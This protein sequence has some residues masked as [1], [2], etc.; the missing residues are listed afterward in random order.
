MVVFFKIAENDEPERGRL[1]RLCFGWCYRQAFV[2]LLGLIDYSRGD[3]IKLDHQ[4]ILILNSFLTL[5][6]QMRFVQK[7]VLNQYH[8]AFIRQEALAT[9]SGYNPTDFETF[10]VHYSYSL[11]SDALKLGDNTRAI[12]VMSG[13][14][15]IYVL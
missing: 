4:I 2:L 1:W 13:V 5:D 3:S 7:Y 14:A 15:I 12:A 8:S 10:A 6:R 11:Y 9:Y